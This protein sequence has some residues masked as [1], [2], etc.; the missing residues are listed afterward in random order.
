[1]YIFTNLMD[2][3]KRKYLNVMCVNVVGMVKVVNVSKCLSIV[4]Y[5]W[6]EEA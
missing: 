3:L 2:V 4:H 1:M 6:N 5:E